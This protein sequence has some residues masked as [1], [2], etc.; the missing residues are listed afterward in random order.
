M[1]TPV[2]VVTG[3]IGV[4]KSAVLH[5][6]DAV[7]V[8]AGIPHATVV[9]EEIARCWSPGLTDP[10]RRAVHR[11]RNLASLWSGYAAQ[12]AERLLMEML[13]E[14]R[15][16]IC[17]IA[18]A[19]PDARVTVVRLRAPLALIEERIRRREFSPD[20]ELAGARWWSLRMDR[21]AVEDFLVDNGRRPPREVAVEVLAAAGWIATSALDVT[22]RDRARGHPPPE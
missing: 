11:H 22:G 1:V 19:I 17:S 8:D 10:D 15:S 12:G 2:L 9:L 18:T 4:G 14:H 21:L 7:L 16:E 20:D 3:P 13:V 6:A 5:A